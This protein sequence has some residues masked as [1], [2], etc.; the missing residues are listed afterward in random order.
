MDKTRGFFAGDLM[1][2]LIRGYENRENPKIDVIMPTWNS[3]TKYF[4]IV[5]KHVIDVLNPHHLIVI[6][7]FSNDGTQEN[8]RKYAGNVLRLVEL[9]VDLAIA[10]RIG[11]LLA[12]TEIVCYIDDDVIIPLRFKSLITRLLDE[13]MNSNK[14][15]VIAFNLCS[16]ESIIKMHQVKV[17]RIIRPLSHLSIKD[18][19]RRGIHPYSR[20][21]TFFFCI[22][23]KLAETWNPPIDLSAYEDYHL[24]QHVVNSGYLW[25]EFSSPCV[26]HVKDYRLRGFYRY[27][28]Q[29]LWEG[30]NAVRAGIPL[31]YIM[32]HVLGRFVG[33]LLNNRPSQFITYIGYSIG[34]L[35]PKRFRVWT[36]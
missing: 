35:V 23:R 14:L 28:K 16:N 34:I 30:A 32:L 13:L 9:D 29:G 11:G 1:R 19:L 3:N 33:S 15:G 22:K 36:R 6:D 31:D 24:S 26:I 7:R 27:L 12:D 5:I 10:R 20:G 8:L 2:P 4:P 21:F 17:S 25:V 18:V